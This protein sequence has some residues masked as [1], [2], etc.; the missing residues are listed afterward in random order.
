[1]IAMEAAVG[2]EQQEVTRLPQVN[3]VFAS[4]SMVV[5]Q[6]VYLSVPQVCEPTYVCVQHN[7]IIVE[8]LKFATA[9]F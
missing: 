8:V 5:G 4:G 1:M 2:Y 7:D 3:K 9:D 6:T